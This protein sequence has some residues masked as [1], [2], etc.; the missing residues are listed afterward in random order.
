MSQ[1]TNYHSAS[2]ADPLQR[3]CQEWVTKRPGPTEMSGL[4]HLWA[5]RTA[6]TEGW[7]KMDWNVFVVAMEIEVR[8]KRAPEGFLLNAWAQY[9]HLLDQAE[10]G[11]LVRLKK[12]W[13]TVLASAAWVWLQSTDQYPIRNQTR[14]TCKWCKRDSKIRIEIISRAVTPIGQVVVGPFGTRVMLDIGVVGLLTI[15]QPQRLQGQS[16]SACH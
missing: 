3:F 8:R 9:A 15:H 14:L 11:H 4:E 5:Q 12:E 10:P 1:F 6:P 16:R 2:A 13:A 7:T